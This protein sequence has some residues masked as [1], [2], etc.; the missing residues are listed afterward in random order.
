MQLKPPAPGFTPRAEPLGGFG[1]F[2]GPPGFSLGCVGGVGL[3]RGGNFPRGNY[4]GGT[5]FSRKGGV[6]TPPRGRQFVE[7][8]PVPKKSPLLG[9]DTGGPHKKG[10]VGGPPP[11]GGGGGRTYFCLQ[12][13]VVGDCILPPRERHP[14]CERKGGIL[15]CVSQ[16]RGSLFLGEL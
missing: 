7:K 12:K 1:D 5:T 3:G 16:T 8:S 11:L 13:E 14:V 10:G 4:L 2:R 6:R 9:C 15:L